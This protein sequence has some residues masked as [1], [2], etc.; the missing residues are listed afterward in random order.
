M[1]RK[2]KKGENMAVAAYLHT[3]GEASRQW[4]PAADGRGKTKGKEC[5]GGVP[6]WSVR[7]LP[8]HW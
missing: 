5:H 1:L 2:V 7:L 6:L 8:S 3:V 4:N